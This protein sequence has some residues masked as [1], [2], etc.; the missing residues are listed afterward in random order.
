MNIL[1]YL[2]VPVI[3]LVAIVILAGAY[4]TGQKYS[5][6]KSTTI[7]DIN[8]NPEAY[9]NRT[10]LIINVTSGGLS[11]NRYAA[12]KDAG[13]K[14]CDYPPCLDYLA[15]GT[16]SICRIALPR[17]TVPCSNEEQ[18]THP[19]ASCSRIVYSGNDLS[20]MRGETSTIKAVLKK[21]HDEE[22]DRT[23]WY[24]EVMEKVRP[25]Q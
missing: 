4:F 7:G 17:K 12:M 13:Y 22:C 8:D 3:F 19:N 21:A 23:Y 6:D 16:G 9:E 14:R 11:S 1:R 20:I 25:L 15:D 18:D 5:E 2:K 10:L 24:L